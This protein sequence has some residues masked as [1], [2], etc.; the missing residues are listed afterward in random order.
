MA[1][2]YD[3]NSRAGAAEPR[4]PVSAGA[5]PTANFAQAQA[6]NQQGNLAEA[7]RICR[8]ILHRQP[9]NFDAVHLLGV[10]ALQTKHIDR[11]IELI[12]RAI[13]LD[14]SSA[15]AHYNLGKA[16][17]ELGYLEKALAA[18]DESIRLKPEFTEAYSDRGIVM[19]KLKRFAD[20]VASYDKAIALKPD[21]A[22]AY[23][24]R[25]NALL[26]LN[27]PDEALTSCDTAIALSPALY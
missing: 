8:E 19:R 10:I 5:V 23:N 18:F 6:F 26:D 15:V 2:S 24:N 12:G 9:N 27:R 14:A 7:E 21:F 4:A 20:A 13:A 1:K 22:M 16:L 11:A 3:P 17:L 25:A